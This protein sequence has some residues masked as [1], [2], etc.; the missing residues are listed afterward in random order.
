MIVS[1]CIRVF[2]GKRRGR[3]NNLLVFQRNLFEAE[4]ENVILLMIFIFLISLS[5]FSICMRILNLV[6][7]LEKYIVMSSLSKNLVGITLSI[8]G[9]HLIQTK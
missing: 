2:S 6:V 7:F 4:E 1:G 8:E 9:D 3:R 5:L